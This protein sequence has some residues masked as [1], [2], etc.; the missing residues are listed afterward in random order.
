MRA[1]ARVAQASLDTNRALLQELKVD[2]Q[3][4]VENEP[5]G[6]LRG[7]LRERVGWYGRKREPRRRRP[8]PAPDLRQQLLQE[9]RVVCRIGDRGAHV[10]GHEAAATA[11]RPG[12]RQASIPCQAQRPSGASAHRHAGQRGSGSLSNM[13]IE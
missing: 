5:R 7:K 2:E 12:R 3:L 9:P 1:E 8:A 11:C 13:D 6:E 10:G 4:R